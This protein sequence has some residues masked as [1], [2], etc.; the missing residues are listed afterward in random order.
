MSS[1]IRRHRRKL[2]WG[3]AAVGG[4]VIAARIVERQM[5][6]EKIQILI[7]FKVYFYDNTL[8]YYFH[9]DSKWPRFDYQ[10]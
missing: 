6:K 1:F 8:D 4:L 5:I 9:I 7:F 2:I 10:K 3:G